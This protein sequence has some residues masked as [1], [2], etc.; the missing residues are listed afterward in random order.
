MNKKF[1]DKWKE[2]REAK[3]I[4]KAEK[5]G[6]PVASEKKEIQPG[7][8]LQ[9][10]FGGQVRINLDKFKG[11]H[12]FIATPAYGGM[13][14]ESYLKAMVRVGILF[15]T[16]NLNFTLATIANESLITRGRNTLTAM[17]MSNPEFTDMMF[18]DADI[19]F[20]AESIIKMWDKLIDGEDEIEVVVGAYPKKSINWQGIIKAVHELGDKATEEEVLK[21]QASYVLNVRSDE[22]GRIPLKNGLL[23]VYDGGTGFMMFSRKVIQKMFDKWPELHY[24]NDLNT[25]PKHDPYMYA[26]FDTIIDPT[27]RRY[28]SEDYTFCRRY[29]E[30]GGTIWMDPSIDLDHQGAYVFKGNISNQFHYGGQATREEADKV[31]QNIN[32]GALPPTPNEQVIE[33]ESDKTE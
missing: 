9:D 27:T 1:S 2:E 18:I 19:H 16:H 8:N 6:K 12:L 29:Q 17:F 26:L 30:L 24:K 32:A 7:D 10:A 23:P 15:K 33:S 20:E 21:Y 5:Q 22:K 3:R 11:R 4:A 31:Q 13:V 14:G 28:L 25:D